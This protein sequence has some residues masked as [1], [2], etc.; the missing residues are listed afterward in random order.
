VTVRGDGKVFVLHVEDALR[1]KTGER[2]AAALGPPRPRHR[3]D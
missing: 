1:I 3:A 2:G